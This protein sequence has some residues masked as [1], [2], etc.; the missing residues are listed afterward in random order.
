MTRWHWII[1]AAVAVVILAMGATVHGLTHVSSSATELPSCYPLSKRG[2]IIGRPYQGSHTLGNWQSDNAVD[3]GIPVGTPV[4]AT[5]SGYIGSNIGSSGLGG[6]YAGLRLTLI[7][8]SNSY[9]YQHLSRLNVRAGQ[10]VVAGQP[11]GRSGR[12]GPAHLHFAVEFGTPYPAVAA[13]FCYY[14]WRL[15]RR[16]IWLR[17]YLGQGE[18]ALFGAANPKHRPR[19]FPRRVPPFVW[20]WERHHLPITTSM[21]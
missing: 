1:L 3:I 12:A 6:R 15:I 11:L 20:R 5:V 4:L 10:H 14:A 19:S 9:F 16:R 7:G 21:G 18:Y 17:W 13:P 8:R 2:P